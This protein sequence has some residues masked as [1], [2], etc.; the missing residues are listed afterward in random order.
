V[1]PAAIGG[2]LLA[3]FA[4]S[5]VTSVLGEWWPID[6]KP[7]WFQYIHDYVVWGTCPAFF[8]TAG[9]ATAPLGRRIVSVALAVAYFGFFIGIPLKFGNEIN[10]S[11]WI[12]IPVELLSALGAVA[13]F[14]ERKKPVAEEE[15]EV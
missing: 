11:G 6:P 3:Q 10:A 12:A 2:V 15:V 4:A 5:E 8:I 9:T 14:Y 1:L 7:H 13:T